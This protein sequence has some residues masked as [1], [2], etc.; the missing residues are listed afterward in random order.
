MRN[1]HQPLRTALAELNNL[2]TSDPATL[3]HPALLAALAARLARP[4]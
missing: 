4:S 1:S 2:S 3:D